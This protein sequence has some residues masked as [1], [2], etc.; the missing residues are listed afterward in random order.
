MKLVQSSELNDEQKNTWTARITNEG[1]TQD[2]I[3]GL[4]ETFQTEIDKGFDTLGIDISD[5]AEFKEKQAE[6]TAEIDAAEGEYKEEMAQIQED[7]KQLE[8]ET[9]KALDELQADII[10]DSIT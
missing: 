5:T 6:M 10:K 2:V 1:L 8:Q 9:A 7:T 3:D 4:K